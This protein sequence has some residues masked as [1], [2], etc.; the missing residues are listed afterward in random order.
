MSITERERERERQRKRETDRKTERERERE[1]ER[2]RELF[3]SPA[4][5]V[6][7]NTQ[8]TC[9]IVSEHLCLAQTDSTARPPPVPDDISSPTFL[10]SERRKTIL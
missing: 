9:Q 2:D 1:S 7:A 5:R 8:F 3:L 10:K 4:S 6:K